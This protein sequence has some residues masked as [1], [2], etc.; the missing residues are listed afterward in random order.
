MIVRISIVR[1]VVD[2]DEDDDDVLTL[3]WT[4]K[5][6]CGKYSSNVLTLFLTLM[7]LYWYTR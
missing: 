4:L 2:K 7:S 6:I 1:I 5:S 3:S